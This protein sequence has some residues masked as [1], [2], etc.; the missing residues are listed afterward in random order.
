M[1]Q[2]SQAREGGQNPGTES[3]P[4]RLRRASSR[5]LRPVLARAARRSKASRPQGSS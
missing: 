5:S 4:W 1:G 3:S 2:N